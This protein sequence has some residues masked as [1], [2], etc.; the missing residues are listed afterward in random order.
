MNVLREKYRHDVEAC[1]KYAQDKDFSVDDRRE[2]LI[3]AGVVIEQYVD[4][5]E[6]HDKF[7]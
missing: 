6:P 7:N 1:Y 4:K 2:F 3:A 5:I